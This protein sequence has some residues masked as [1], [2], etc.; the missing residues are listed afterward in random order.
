VALSELA[1]AEE[2]RYAKG[3]FRVTVLKNRMES[4]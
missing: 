2:A 3:A 1:K 4:K